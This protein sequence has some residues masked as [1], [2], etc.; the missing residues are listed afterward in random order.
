MGLFGKHVHPA[1]IC[2]RCSD[3]LFSASHAY[4][5]WVC[6]YLVPV[7]FIDIW[8][9]DHSKFLNCYGETF[10]RVERDFSIFGDQIDKRTWLVK[11]LSPIL[12][13]APDIHLSSL[14]KMWVDGLVYKSIGE[15]A[16]EKLSEEWRE[17]VFFVSSSRLGEWFRWTNSHGTTCRLSLCWLQT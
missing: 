2:Y 6:L 9:V 5:L 11:T 1:T 3:L 7:C 16:I 8:R 4:L 12:F 10:S 15:D 13:S 17:F 14:Q